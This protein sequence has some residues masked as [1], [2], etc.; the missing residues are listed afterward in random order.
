MCYYIIF[1]SE[2]LETTV[3]HSHNVEKQLLECFVATEC[4]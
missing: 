2:L 4:L 3:L 1:T